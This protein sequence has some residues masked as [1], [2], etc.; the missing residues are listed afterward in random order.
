M[1]KGARKADALPLPAGKTNTTLP[2]DRLKA[3][4]QFRFNEVEQLCR[5]TRFAQLLR[6]N[7]VFRQAKRD[8]ARDRVV[9]EKDVLWHVTGRSLPGGN[10]RGR[11][12]PAIDQDLACGWLIEPKQ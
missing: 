2:H 1:V 11:K 6:I 4:R 10:Q 3:G 12:G 7:L 9:Y 8:V 5:H